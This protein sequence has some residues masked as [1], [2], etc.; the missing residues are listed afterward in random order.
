MFE[1]IWCMAASNITHRVVGWTCE[2]PCD[3]RPPRPLLPWRK[4]ALNC[5]KPMLCVH[6]FDGRGNGRERCDAVELAH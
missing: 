2:L 5:P 6:T 4:P 3:I 1:S